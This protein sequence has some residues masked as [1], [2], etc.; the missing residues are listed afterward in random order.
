MRRNLDSHEYVLKV[1]DS[2]AID[3]VGMIVP[4]PR[5]LNYL[6]FI[7]FRGNVLACET[8]DLNEI[9]QFIKSIVI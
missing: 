8:R 7:K 9:R 4:V 2:S 1:A 6:K 3:V 5:F